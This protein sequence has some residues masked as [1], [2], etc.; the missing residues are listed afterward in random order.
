VT[1]PAVVLQLEEVSGYAW[2]S[3]AFLQTTRLVARVSQLAA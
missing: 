1:D 2:R 3:P